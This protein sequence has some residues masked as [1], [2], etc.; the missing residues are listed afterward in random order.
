MVYYIIP[1]SSL[2]MKSILSYVVACNFTE[3]ELH[4]FRITLKVFSEHCIAILAIL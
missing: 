3:K 4:D 1:L 2:S